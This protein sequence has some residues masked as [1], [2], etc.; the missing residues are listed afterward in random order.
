MYYYG[1]RGI[2]YEWFKTYLYNRK[3]HVIIDNAKSDVKVL[4]HGVP[5]G[6]VLGPLLFLLYIND[7]QNCC[8]LFDFHI[9]ADDTNIFSTNKSLLDL[10]SIVNANLHHISKRLSSNKLSLNIDKTSFV[11]F[12]SPQKRI[13]NYQ[14]KLYIGTKEIKHDKC[15][16]YLGVYFDSSLTWKSHISYV[17]KKVKRCNGI[18]FKLSGIDIEY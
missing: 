3:Q 1:I 7:F 10:E 2:A 8:N 5:Q 4:T 14:F 16:K 12:H 15:I 17:S 6:S 13:K 9:F 18:L 11:I